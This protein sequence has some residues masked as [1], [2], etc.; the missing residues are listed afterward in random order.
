MSWSRFS[1]GDPRENS[2]WRLRPRAGSRH[3]LECEEV[4]NAVSGE[5]LALNGSQLSRSRT[6]TRAATSKKE[7]K[8]VAETERSQH[9]EILEVPAGLLAGIA[10][11]GGNRANPGVKFFG[12]SPGQ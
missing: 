12:N 5:K 7:N 2:K 10:S 3:F 8:N 9:W 1:S 11:R 4:W 6:E